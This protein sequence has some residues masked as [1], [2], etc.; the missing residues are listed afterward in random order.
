MIQT[1]FNYS[2]FNLNCNNRVGYHE[3]IQNSFSLQFKKLIYFSVKH[4]RVR[5]KTWVPYQIIEFHFN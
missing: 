2:S 3:N 1:F 4:Y 5:K